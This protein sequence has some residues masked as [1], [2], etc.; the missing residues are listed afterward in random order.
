MITSN[1]NQGVLTMAKSDNVGI[2]EAIKIISGL[3]EKPEQVAQAADQI[4]KAIINAS[5]PTK[6]KKSVQNGNSE[7][8]EQFPD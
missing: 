2:L 5:R 7:R 6:Q 1:H 8:S 3:V 4:Q